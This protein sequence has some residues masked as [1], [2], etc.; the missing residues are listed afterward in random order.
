MEHVIA[1]AGV[2]Q[3]RYDAVDQ[4]GL[5]RTV[6]AFDDNEFRMYGLLV[7][8]ESCLHLSIPVKCTA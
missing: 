3:M 2:I 1:D 4:C 7:I 6:D 8:R 5:T